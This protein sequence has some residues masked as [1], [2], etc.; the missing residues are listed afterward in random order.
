M[1]HQLK[2]PHNLDQCI[3]LKII[4]VIGVPDYSIRIKDVGIVSSGITSDV[5]GINIDNGLFG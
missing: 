3:K 2:L 5:A 4:D 1:V